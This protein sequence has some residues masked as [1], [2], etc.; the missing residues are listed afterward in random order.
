MKKHLGFSSASAPAKAPEPGLAVGDAPEQVGLGGGSIS[1][2]SPLPQD[3]VV[4]AGA[5]ATYGAVFRF[6]FIMRKNA[7]L[8]CDQ[9][10][11]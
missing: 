7:C 4:E 6:H 5:I 8:S 9:K 2:R 1:V 10:N 3:C 11:Q